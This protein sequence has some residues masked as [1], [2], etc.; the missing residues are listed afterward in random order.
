MSNDV[1]S[2]VFS[3]GDL[4]RIHG[5]VAQPQLNGMIGVVKAFHKNSQRYEIQPSRGSNTLGVKAMNL[6]D[7]DFLKP[8]DD[9][10]TT[11]QLYDN[12]FL[13]PSIRKAT[14]DT[15]QCFSDFPSVDFPTQ[16]DEYIKN[17]LGWKSVDTLVGIKEPGREK[18]SFLLLFDGRDESSPENRTASKTVNLLPMY[19]RQQCSHYNGVIRGVAI[20]VYSPMNSTYSSF[21]SVSSM[22]MNGQ[23]FQFIESNENRRFTPQLLYDVIQFHKTD[24]AKR[25]YR[26][27]D[28]PMHRVFG[29]Q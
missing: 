1:E 12:I 28:N 21:S 6:S 10:F 14:R 26:S 5:L 15:I 7:R 4:V 18:P 17:I 24:R 9:K 25:Q 22:G 19:E 23:Q 27:H 16:Q 11:E 20:L 2:K 8:T 29:I 13:W 3:A